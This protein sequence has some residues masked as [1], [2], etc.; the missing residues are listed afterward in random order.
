MPPLRKTL[1]S[2]FY[3]QGNGG[4]EKIIPLLKFRQRK[5]QGSSPVISKDLCVSYQSTLSLLGIEIGDLY[6]EINEFLF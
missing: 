4:S 3:R 2:T 6:L 1:L 5:S